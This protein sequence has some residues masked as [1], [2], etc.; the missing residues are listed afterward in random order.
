MYE[1]SENELGGS[2]P[3]SE[4]QTCLERGCV[5][6]MIM[7]ATSMGSQARFSRFIVCR[8]KLRS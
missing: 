4:W 1:G 2:V 3:L 5:R 7:A 6:I 8:S